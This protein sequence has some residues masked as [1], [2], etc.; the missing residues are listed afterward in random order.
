[1]DKI[2]EQEITNVLQ[3]LTQRRNTIQE[4]LK[5][6]GAMVPKTIV[7][8]HKITLQNLQI[9]YKFQTEWPSI[10]GPEKYDYLD[11]L[12][13]LVEDFENIEEFLYRELE[14]STNNLLQIK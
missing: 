11:R 7:K 12:R 6:Y 4:C 8:L 9:L 10:P 13:E 2:L 5:L 1:M 3:N 14:H